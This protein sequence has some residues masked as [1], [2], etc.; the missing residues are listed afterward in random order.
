MVLILEA[1]FFDRLILGQDPYLFF[2]QGVNKVKI[3]YR[4]WPWQK[5]NKARF[6]SPTFDLCITCTTSIDLWMS[7]AGVDTFVL[8]VH[9]LNNKWDNYWI[10]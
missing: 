7:R 5:K 3:F 10:F 8:I 1:P 6:I 4:R 2:H 9:F